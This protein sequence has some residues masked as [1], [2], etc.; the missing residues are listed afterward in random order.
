MLSLS[1]KESIQNEQA[2]L[3]QPI[4]FQ[5]ISLSLLALHSPFSTSFNQQAHFL[6]KIFQ[7]KPELPDFQGKFQPGLPRKLDKTRLNQAFN[8]T[9]FF[10]FQK[11]S[12]SGSSHGLLVTSSKGI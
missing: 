12:K 4:F 8:F 11:S 2:T 5:P 3:F 1:D 7:S 9:F 10:P 6:L